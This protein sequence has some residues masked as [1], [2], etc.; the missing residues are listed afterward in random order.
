MILFN[1][2]NFAFVKA[3]VWRMTLLKNSSVPFMHHTAATHDCTLPVIAN[4][5]LCENQIEFLF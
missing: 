5:Q 1:F 4:L 3:L 2:P